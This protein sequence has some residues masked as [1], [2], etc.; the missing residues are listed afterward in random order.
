M[1]NKKASP[2]VIGDVT[3]TETPVIRAIPKVQPLPM[4]QSAVNVK[5][6]WYLLAKI[7]ANGNEIPGTE[8]QVSKRDY[9]RTF[10]KRPEY[11]VKKNPNP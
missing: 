8:V 4:S 3:V 5:P 7:D 10:S 9:D 2:I 11:V 6:G 1:A